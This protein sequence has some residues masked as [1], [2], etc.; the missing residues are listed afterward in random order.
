MLG[1]LPV[2]ISANSSASSAKVKRKGRPELPD[3]DLLG[4]LSQVPAS[5]SRFSRRLRTVISI[6]LL[7]GGLVAGTASLVATWRAFTPVGAR[8]SP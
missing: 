8:G 1:R 3:R 5:W 7:E 6:T 4:L 2:M